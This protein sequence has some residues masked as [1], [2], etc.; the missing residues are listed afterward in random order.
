MNIKTVFRPTHKNTAVLAA[1]A[2]VAAI[3]LT[4]AAPANAAKGA[5][6]PVK[7]PTVVLVHGAFVDASSWNPVIKRLQHDGYPV[8]AAANPLRGLANDSAYLRSLLDS[9]KGPIVL[10]GHSYGGSVI[11]QAAAGDPDVKAL[12]YIAAF[13]PDKGE[14]ATELNEK[15]P[16]AELGSAL[17]AVPFP[18]PGGDTG[19][20]LYVKADKF[21]HVFA[22][23]VPTSLTDLAAA[24]QRPVA[25]SVFGDEST[26]A[27]WKTIPSWTLI[28]TQDKA[29]VPAEQRFMA[30]RAHAHT[31]EVKSSH[32]VTLSHPGAVSRLIERA[33][34]TTVR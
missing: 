10:A 12:V 5:H 2:G 20:D 34:A 15:F 9:I 17:N 7:K 27:A 30:Q 6:Q 8:V 28:T 16:G 32:A 13:A 33:A 3:A 31:V 18:L 1:A 14:S 19:T 4:A 21:H 22:S 23:D 24:G 26:E 29:I 25:A 11:S